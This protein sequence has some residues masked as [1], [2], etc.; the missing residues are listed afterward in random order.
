MRIENR[1]HIRPIMLTTTWKDEKQ[2]SYFEISTNF[3]AKEQL[4][5]DNVGSGLPVSNLR[6]TS[7]KDEPEKGG[8]SDFDYKALL[9][10]AEED[11]SMT[12]QML[13]ESSNI[14]H[15]TIIRRLKKIGKVWKL[16]GWVPKNSLTTTRLIEFEFLPDSCSETYK[17][18]FWKISS[19]VTNQGYY[20]K[21][22][23]EKVLRFATCFIQINTKRR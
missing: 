17:H 19:R 10:M 8:W 4:A 22:S 2:H 1:I 21:T 11:D 18:H 16:V 9:A 5:K 20:S 23:K 15:S 6:N 12:T 7:L 3:L 13:A 14:Y